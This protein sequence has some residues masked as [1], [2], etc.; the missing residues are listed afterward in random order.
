MPPQHT[1]VHMAHESSYSVT[2]GRLLTLSNLA[3]ISTTSVSTSSM[4]ALEQA[5]QV[6]PAAALTGAS[7]PGPADR[8]SW[9]HQCP[10][11]KPHR[12]P[13]PPGLCW[14]LATTAGAGTVARALSPS[15]LST[16]PIGPW[17][18]HRSPDLLACALGKQPEAIDSVWWPAQTSPLPPASQCSCREARQGGVNT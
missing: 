15:C 4:V 18:A 3:S 11:R 16:G 9:H 14:A 6:E 10:N 17:T 5:G 12:P 8:G 1:R 7:L 2:P 13:P